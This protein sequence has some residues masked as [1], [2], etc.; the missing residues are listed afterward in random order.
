[1]KVLL[2]E[3]ETVLSEAISEALSLSGCVVQLAS[4]GLDAFVLLDS[5][6]PDVIVC[7]IKMPNIDGYGFLGLVRQKPSLNRIPFIVISAKAE[8]ADIRK[9][10]ISGADDYI[11]KP[12]Q[13]DTLV[14]S[15]YM[16]LKRFKAISQEPSEVDLFQAE[17]LASLSAR[18]KEVFNLIGK[19]LSNKQIAAKLEISPK[20]VM[21]HRQRIMEKLDLIGHGSL[22]SYILD[23]K[24]Q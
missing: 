15:M 18:E 22:F 24:N 23:L 16:R 19:G 17:E 13:I 1:M 7:D 11:T 6:R 5:Y 8:Q 21:N 3:D 10:M 20:T 12:F 9:A 4:D 2:V 14:D